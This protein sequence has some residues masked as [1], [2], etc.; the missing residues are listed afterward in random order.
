[1]ITGVSAT[2]C[3]SELSSE[4]I[5]ASDLIT[6]LDQMRQ[7]IKVRHCKHACKVDANSKQRKL[8]Q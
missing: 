5:K 8:A 2:A 1:M 4:F 6:H 7:T 3:I